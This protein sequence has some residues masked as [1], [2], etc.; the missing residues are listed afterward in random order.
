MS[1]TT[2]L[3][4]APE[5]ELEAAATLPALLLQQARTRPHATAIRH[6]TLG[7]WRS[8]SWTEALRE[9]VLAAEVLAAGGFT[10]RDRLLVL[11]DGSPELVFGALGAQLLGGAVIPLDGH[12]QTD[13]V[14][15]VVESGAARFAVTSGQAA[16]DLLFTASGTERLARAL[17][18]GVDL[19]LDPSSRVTE[20]RSAVAAASQ[21]EPD[22]HSVATRVAALKATQTAFR[23]HERVA[24]SSE[25]RIVQIDHGRLLEAAAE[26]VRRD[27]LKADDELFAPVRL[28]ELPAL[29]V[30]LVGWLAA[31]CRLG[32]A[33]NAE[34]ID[35]DR[36]ELGPTIQVASTA[37]YRA[38]V[39]RVRLRFGSPGSWRR[40]L[41]ESSLDR[42]PDSRRGVTG[43][44]PLSWRWFLVLRPLRDVIGLTRV[45]LAATTDGELD[46]DVE[47]F[48]QAL[49]V[50]VA[51]LARA[52]R[53]THL[54]EQVSQGPSAAELERKARASEEDDELE[55]ADEL[56][57]SPLFQGGR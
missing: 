4:A 36:R 11:G 30:G 10:A 17:A 54:G 2:S 1:Q 38:L 51:E 5:R 35:A 27:G 19:E 41:I 28:W 37:D 14:D 8:W 32:I 13:L 33:E 57:P 49:R 52:H 7:I 45:R 46:P 6:K 31:G 44:S 39:E 55:P 20:Y 15:A 3:P 21:S 12:A 50:S 56:L 16:L 29:P 48:L 9:A 22:R 26:A 42:A 53:T 34:T 40:K 24:G 18:A 43:N 47:R 25:V 23:Y